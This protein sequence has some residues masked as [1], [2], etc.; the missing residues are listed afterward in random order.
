VARSCQDGQQCGDCAGLAPVTGCL[1]A[2]RVKHRVGI[3]LKQ[4]EE[5]VV[6]PGDGDPQMCDRIRREVLEVLGEEY[7]CAARD[8]CGE[9]VP[10][11][12][13]LAMAPGLAAYLIRAP[14]STGRV[15]P[16]M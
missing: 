9:Y 15:T 11:L 10:V 12:K 5:E 14:A 1:T 13:S 4:P 6:L 3:E 2:E 8:G 16:V 7:V